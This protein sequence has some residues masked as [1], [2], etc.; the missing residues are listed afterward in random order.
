MKPKTIYVTECVEVLGTHSFTP[1]LRPPQGGSPQGG[2][3][4]HL[5]TGEVTGF[6]SPF[7]VL[8]LL[9]NKAWAICAVL[10]SLFDSGILRGNEVRPNRVECTS[11]L[12]RASHRLRERIHCVS[13]VCFLQLVQQDRQKGARKKVQETVLRLH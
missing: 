13:G 5:A 7:S 10:G 1:S 11:W 8:S 3:L 2:R 6:L 4:Q 9:Q 12:L